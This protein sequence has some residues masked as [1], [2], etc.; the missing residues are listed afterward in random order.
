[1][2]CSV[3]AATVFTLKFS[4]FV[5]KLDWIG[6][7]GLYWIKVDKSGVDRKDYIE[8]YYIRLNKI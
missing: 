6:L 5:I 7:D 1:M 8:K 3:V 2:E 4:I